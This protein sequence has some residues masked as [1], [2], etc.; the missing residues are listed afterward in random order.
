MRQGILFIGIGRAEG[1]LC[2]NWAT[3]CEEPLRI[4][5]RHWKKYLKDANQYF[6]GELIDNKDIRH[7]YIRAKVTINDHWADM[8]AYQFVNNRIFDAL[9]CGL[10]VISDSFD[11]LRKLFPNEVLYYNDKYS[12]YECIKRLNEDYDE[13]KKRVEGLSD[14]IKKEYSFDARAKSLMKITN[15][16]ANH[17]NDK[18]EYAAEGTRKEDTWDVVLLWKQNDTGIYGR[19]HDM[20]MKYFAEDAK[21]HKIIVFDS[22]IYDNLLEKYLEI[23]KADST[24][25]EYYIENLARKKEFGYS[26]SQKIT[27][28][29]YIIPQN[30]HYKAADYSE[31]IQYVKRKEDLGK[32]NI[33][34]WV[35]PKVYDF[36]LFTN[37]LDVD[38]MVSDFIDDEREF[39]ND[40]KEKDKITQNYYKLLCRSDYVFCNCKTVYNN[41]IELCPK[42][43][44]I[45]N[46]IPNAVE[47]IDAVE[48][49]ISIPKRLTH[50]PHPIIGYAGNFSSRFDVEL[51][52]YLS[53]KHP[54][55]HFVF[56][57]STLIDKRIL[58]LKELKERKNIHI[59]GVVPYKE[60]PSYLQCFD[61]AIMPH[62]AND[63]SIAMNPLKLF[64][65]ALYRKPI[66][67]SNVP[68]IDE[69]QPLA[70]IAK[71]AVEFENLIMLSLN[72]GP[73]IDDKE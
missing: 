73:K 15:A 2:V 27:A 40:H 72:K 43:K 18:K 49:D 24:T 10:P 28:Y 55:W 7:E 37:N 32:R 56:I 25:R 46:V 20:L 51:I 31:Y 4:F 50:I 58:E 45:I 61:V 14:L 8:K 65:Y 44:E 13:I 3:E 57:G 68:N 21:I 9:A 54:G 69:V 39:Y 16:Y 48:A 23:G 70:Y 47:P 64:V 71:D 5:G 38:I 59:L 52:N 53:T 6:A 22:P 26:D 34:L 67:S 11:E 62:I 35:C 1:R 30:K 60:L 12:F 42:R 17:K 66:V 19:R 63:Q 33:L 36:E 29:N 41:L